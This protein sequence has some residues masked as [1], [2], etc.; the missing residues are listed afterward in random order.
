MEFSRRA[1]LKGLGLVTAA[2]ALEGCATFIPNGPGAE[3]IQDIDKPFD[4]LSLNQTL[5]R[6]NVLNTP[7]GSQYRL[8]VSLT[9]PEGEPAVFRNTVEP[10]SVLRKSVAGMV[11]EEV[12][13]IELMNR[14]SAMESARDVDTQMVVEAAQTPGRFVLRTEPKQMHRAPEIWRRHEAQKDS[15]A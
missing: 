8:L 12:D 2:T 4:N 5:E 10:K 7:K 9:T 11:R 1:L 3:D 15:R 13:V 6:I 14:L